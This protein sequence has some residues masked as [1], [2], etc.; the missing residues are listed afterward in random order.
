MALGKDLAHRLELNKRRFGRKD[1]AYVAPSAHD[2]F[3]AVLKV[4]R[5]EKPPKMEKWSCEELEAYIRKAPELAPLMAR[6]GVGSERTFYDDQARLGAKWAIEHLEQRET[7]N[8][9][10]QDPFWLAV[11]ETHPQ[12]PDLMLSTAQMD[13]A[14]A[15]TIRVFDSYRVIL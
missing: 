10:R 15:A 11:R 1:P 14:Y 4:S 3:L 8:G 7:D 6:R 2:H 13:W 9:L 5:G 12:L